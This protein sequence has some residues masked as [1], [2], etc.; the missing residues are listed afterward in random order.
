MTKLCD[1]ENDSITSLNWVQKGSLI[2]IGTFNGRIQIWDAV[3]CVRLRDY[4]GHHLRVGALAWNDS[5]I[6]SGS[7]DR[8]IQNRDVR[9]PGKAYQTLTS[10]RQEVCGLK[11]NGSQQQLASG[12]NDNKLL[13]WDHRGGTPDSPLWKWHEHS[14]A[15]KAIAWNPHQPGVLASG[16][17]TADKKMRFWNT[18]A[19][20]LLAEVDTG[21][22][23]CLLEY[24]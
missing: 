22:Q 3:K 10:H 12:G 18:M 17:G 1:L 20:N 5:T 19:G 23:V 14:A 21:S 11:W 2:A 4:E 15:V 9:A 6:T 16:G 7:R 13:I 8:T 24:L